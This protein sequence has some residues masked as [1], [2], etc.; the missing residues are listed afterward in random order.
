MEEILEKNTNH[1]KMISIIEQRIR[2]VKELLVK[3]GSGGGWIL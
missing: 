2:Y 1:D 3:K